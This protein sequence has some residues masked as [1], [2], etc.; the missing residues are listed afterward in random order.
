M[1]VIVIGGIM[2]GNTTLAEV[3][4]NATIV[5]TIDIMMVVICSS[6][7]IKEIKI[8]IVLI[9]KDQD[10]KKLEGEMLMIDPTKFS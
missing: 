10:A 8:N 4:T 1:V 3:G 5:Q 9:K 7:Q 2:I 6:F